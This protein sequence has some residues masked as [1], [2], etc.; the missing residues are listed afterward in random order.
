MD[1][2][3]ITKWIPQNKPVIS[4]NIILFFCFSQRIKS[5][6]PRLRLRQYILGPGLSLLV[7]CCT[8]L[9]F[10]AFMLYIKHHIL[11]LS[12]RCCRPSICCL[13]YLLYVVHHNFICCQSY[14]IYVICH[15]FYMLPVIHTLYTLSLVQDCL[16]LC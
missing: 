6:A 12:S 8:F 10:L 3:H 14:L 11:S 16:I 4:F 9:Y 13:S 1:I 15:T 2:D 5:C 7:V